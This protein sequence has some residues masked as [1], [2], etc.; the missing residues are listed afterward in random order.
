[1]KPFSLYHKHA[2]AIAFQQQQLVDIILQI[3]KP[4]LIYLLGASLHRRRSESIFCSEAPTSQHTADYYL[5]VLLPDFNNREQYE[6]QDM[7]EQ[8]CSGLM[9]VTTIVLKTTTFKEWLLDGHHFARM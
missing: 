3:V 8:H 2:A 4:D 5:L 9:P 1:M 7:I 6:W